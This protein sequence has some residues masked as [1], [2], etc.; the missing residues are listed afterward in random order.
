MRICVCLL[1]TILLLGATGCIEII[2]D[3]SMNAD[4]SGTFRYTVNLSSSK[5]KVNSYLSIDSLDGKKVPEKADIIVRIDGIIEE[6]RKQEG[7][8]EVTFDGNYTDYLF[9]LK[10][11]FE[12]VED[13]QV[14]VK[15]VIKAEYNANKIEELNHNWLSY[16][17]GALVRSVPKMTIYKVSE[18]SSNDIDLLKNG[19]Y[20]SITR[21][22]SEIRECSNEVASISKNKQ[23][24]MLKSDPYSLIR[25]SSL[26][27]ITIELADT[28]D[29]N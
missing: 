12:T 9:K 1:W 11:D 7:I 6:L 20:L 16:K 2:D 26:L 18:L 22:T 27:D 10:V 13:L 14:A 15:N 24:V 25:E 21:F 8:T 17:G 23:A 19:N 29:T 28:S 3:L 4:G 5:V